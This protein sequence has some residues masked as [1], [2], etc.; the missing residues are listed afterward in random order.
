MK[1]LLRALQYFR[2][3]AS[4]IAFVFALLLLSVGANLLK[5]WPLALIVDCVI[6]EKPLPAWLGEWGGHAAKAWGRRGM[7]TTTLA[8]TCA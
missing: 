4:R 7:T 5:P 3:D 8:A 1:N 6:G 2:P